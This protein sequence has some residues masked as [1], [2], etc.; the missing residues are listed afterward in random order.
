MII[1]PELETV[2][3]CPP[4][5]GSTSL[6]YAIAERYAKSFMLYRHMEADAIPQGYDRWAKVGLVRHPID[7]LWSLYFYCKYKIDPSSAKHVPE[8]YAD[9]KIPPEVTFSEWVMGNK[10]IFTVSHAADNVFAAYSVR[11]AIPETR[12][13]QF[14]TLRPDLGTQVYR[15]NHLE[16]LAGRLD[17]DLKHLN[18]SAAHNRKPYDLT[19]VAEDHI[20]KYFKWDL[21]QFI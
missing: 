2:V 19:D 15:F 10:S 3:L 14:H 21:E 6:K 1:I 8:W 13:S 16:L 17:L 12:K 4:R 20:K 9:V 5:T 18:Y 7:R 11:H